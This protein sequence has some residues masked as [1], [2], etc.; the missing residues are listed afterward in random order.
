MDYLIIQLKKKI[1]A[2]ASAFK[3]VFGKKEIQQ[4]EPVSI[5]FFM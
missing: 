4:Q 3:S 2:A 5:G 1:T